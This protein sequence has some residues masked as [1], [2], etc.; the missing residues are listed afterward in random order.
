MDEMLSDP[1]LPGIAL[2]ARYWVERAEYE[3]QQ[4]EVECSIKMLSRGVSYG[5]KVLELLCL[6]QQQQQQI[7]KQNNDFNLAH[8]NFT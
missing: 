6:K 8:E 3:L 7:N 4:G 2:S 5:A 1:T